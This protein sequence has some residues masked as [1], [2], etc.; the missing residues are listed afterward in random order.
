MLGWRCGKLPRVSH[1]SFDAE[2]IEVV[3]ALD[4]STGVSMLIQEGLEGPR[5]TLVELKLQGVPRVEHDFTVKVELHTDAKCLTSRVDK[6][7]QDPGMRK[8]RK[9]D[10]ADLRDSMQRGLVSSIKHITGV[11]NP[12]DALTK[13]ASKTQKTMLRLL[14]VVRGCYVPIFS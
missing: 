5:Q 12:C 4:A 13:R 8:A 3:D 6:L 1:S 9:T 2:T 11:D 7:T 10:I 14:E